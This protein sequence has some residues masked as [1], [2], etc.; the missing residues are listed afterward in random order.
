MKA[1]WKILLSSTFISQFSCHNVEEWLHSFLL[2]KRTSTCMAFK[3][4]M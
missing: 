1:W 3:A 2:H 4:T